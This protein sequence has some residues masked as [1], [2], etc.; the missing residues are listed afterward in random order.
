M[1]LYL[2]SYVLCIGIKKMFRK[3]LKILNQQGPKFF[4]F[5]LLELWFVPLPTF[6]AVFRRWLTKLMRRE[7]GTKLK[8]KTRAHQVFICICFLV[9]SLFMLACFFSWVFG[10]ATSFKQ[11]KSARGRFSLMFY[12]CL[13]RR[14]NGDPTIFFCDWH[15][16]HGRIQ[17]PLF[18]S[19]ANVGAKIFGRL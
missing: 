10:G 7:N 6:F 1:N 5:V 14:T 12:T 17:K 19:W 18:I 2:S 4:L 11:L 9:V 15:V 8:K 13:L 3:L 16:I